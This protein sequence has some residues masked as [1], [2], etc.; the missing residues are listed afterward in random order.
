[1]STEIM[2][3]VHL[4]LLASVYLTTHLIEAFVMKR[5]SEFLDSA[6]MLIVEEKKTSMG[7]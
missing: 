1:M 6:P 7:D 5:R 3:K 2:S 4:T